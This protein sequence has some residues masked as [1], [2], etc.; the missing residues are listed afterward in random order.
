[1]E[2]SALAG[3][4]GRAWRG[5][6]GVPQAGTHHEEQ[7]PHQILQN[8]GQH[9]RGRQAGAAGRWA[10]QAGELARAGRAVVG[11]APHACLCW[12][13]LAVRKSSAVPVQW[14]R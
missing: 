9:C 11:R 14:Q 13:V 6:Q 5:R 4:G 1:M 8:D 12:Q 3:Q 7:A 10:Q 2:G